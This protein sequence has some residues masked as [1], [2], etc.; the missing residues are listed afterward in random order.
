MK[1]LF[2]RIML[3]IT[4]VIMT[5][6]ALYAGTASA[7]EAKKDFLG[8][9]FPDFTVTDSE[10]N[11]FT[12]C[13]AL[14]DHEAVLI[15]FWATWCGPCRNEFPYLNE[16]YEKYC[17][18]VAF[19]ALSSDPKDTQEKIEAFRRENGISFPMGCDEGK[20]LYGYISASG[21]PDTVVIDRF[22]NAAFF[23][24]GVF[25]STTEAELVLEAFLGDG[26]TET[27]VL[28]GIPRDTSTRSFP[29]SSVRAVYPAAGNYRKILFHMDANQKPVTGYIIPEDSVS[30]RIEVAA[31]D[32]VVNMTLMDLNQ[33]TTTDVLSL[34][35]PE[36]GVYVFEQKMAGPE[37]EEAC[38]QL[39]L[40]DRAVDEDD[41]RQCIVFLFPNEESI[42]RLAEQMKAMSAGK[43]SWEYTENTKA[44]TPQA[45]ILH[46]VD[47]E[48]KP[49]EEVSVNFC[50]ETA[51][52]SRE[53]DQ[54][55]AIIFDGVPDIY[56][57]QI[58]DVPDGYSWDEDYEM[59]TNRE[60]GEWVLRVR[61][62]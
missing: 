18:R 12:L 61:K 10:G 7:E 47:Q 44:E 11:P 34:L 27:A 4:C 62:D 56:H 13:E 33:G 52:V 14:K 42:G 15:N 48:N 23:H 21:I 50:T 41:D 51:C 25:R 1:D 8:K 55:G 29:V 2:F 59:Y 43:V 3:L 58:I 32:D 46:V 60:Y 36:H 37:D 35:D 26:Y 28:D 5:M 40:Y 39:Q 31:D 6:P 9:P 22:G 24:A 30:L 19:I 16:A 38:V 53:S 45:Y 54:N 17:G 49:V 57:V 20:E